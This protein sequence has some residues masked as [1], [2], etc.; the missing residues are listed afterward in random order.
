[1]FGFTVNVCD[2][3]S[4]VDASAIEYLRAASRWRTSILERVMSGYVSKVQVRWLLCT[5]ARCLFC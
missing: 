4:I 3:A 2:R 1:M 5:G